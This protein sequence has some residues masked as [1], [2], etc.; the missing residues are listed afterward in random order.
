MDEKIVAFRQNYRAN[1]SAHYHPHFH[2]FF[3]FSVGFVVILYSVLQLKQISVLEWLT[4]PIT[5]VCVNFAEYAAHR[6]LGHRRTKIGGF[7]Y[8]RHTG[9]HHH[10][11]DES[12]MNWETLKDWRV[13]LFPAYLII[14][15]ILGVALPVGSVLYFWFSSNVAYLVVCSAIFGYLL[16]EALHLSFHVPDDTYLKKIPFWWRLKRLH[17]L[18]HEHKLMVKKNFNITY[19]LFDWLLSTLYFDNKGDR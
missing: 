16:Y 6:W 15:F 5:L 14:A 7:F 1:M 17:V 10:F 13:V 2:F 11:F 9:D 19:P 4:V 3:V 12:T 8:Q 18:H